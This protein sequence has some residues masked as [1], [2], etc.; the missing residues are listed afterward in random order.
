MLIK[1]GT[2]VKR[3][4]GLSVFSYSFIR[5]EIVDDDDDDDDDE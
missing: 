1:N 2:F 4:N 5:P 3:N